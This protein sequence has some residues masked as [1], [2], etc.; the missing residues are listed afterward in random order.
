M[1]VATQIL[2]RKQ[3]GERIAIE[4]IEQLNQD[5]F[6]VKSQR[7]K[8]GYSVT[9]TGKSWACDCCDF[10]YRQLPCKHIHAVLNIMEQQG[11]NSRYK[12]G[13]W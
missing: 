1:Y 7:G 9:R 5:T 10:K 6:F 11:L 8:S 2:T 13:L 4:D 12:L 3:R